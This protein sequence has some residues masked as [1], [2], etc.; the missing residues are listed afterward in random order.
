[1]PYHV[2]F[3]DDIAVADMAFEAVADSAPELFTAATEAMIESLA[4]PATVGR[5]WQHDVDRR[6]Q[7]LASLLFE[8]LEEL[9]Y[10]KDAHGVVFH[11]ATLT[12]ERLPGDSGWRL[13]GRLHGEPVAPDRQALRSD[14]KGVTKHLYDVRQEG[15]RWKARVVLDV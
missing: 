12:L 13:H 11:K 10:L 8:W 5:T 7:D 3:L 15:G 2:T 6:A 4:D 9:T 1:M 14:V